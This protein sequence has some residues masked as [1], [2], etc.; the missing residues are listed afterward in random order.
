MILSGSLVSFFGF[1]RDLSSVILFFPVG[2]QLLKKEIRNNSKV[3]ETNLT[4][5]NGIFTS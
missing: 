3:L 2:G 1:L 5:K 4:K